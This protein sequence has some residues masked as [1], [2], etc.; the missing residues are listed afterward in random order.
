LSV[1]FLKAYRFSKLD[2]PIHV[3]D[4]RVKL[5]AS[6]CFTILAI[7]TF[8]PTEIALLLII[9]L[10]ILQISKSLSHWLKSLRSLAFFVV[11]ILASQYLTTGQALQSIYFAVRFIVIASATSWFF[12]TTSP[13]EM[14][15]ALEES[16]FP[17]D[18]AL[19]F[20]LSMRFIP[21]I[22]DEFQSIFDAQ[23]ARGLELDR[24]GFTSRVRSFL[25]ILVPLFI[26]IIR[27]T[28]EIADALELRGYGAHPFRT[29]WKKLE[30]KPLDFAAALLFLVLVGV[31]LFHRFIVF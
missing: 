19:S 28:Y 2:T 4:P 17:A 13:E 25:P 11:L 1:A 24:G 15:R 8:D 31:I 7:T 26:E 3:L 12:F 14:G 10:A 6:V 30:L 29:H 5:I 9:Q 18:I 20:T 22:A 21:V 27:R 23:R 16:G